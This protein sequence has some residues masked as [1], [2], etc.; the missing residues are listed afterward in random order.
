VELG[1]PEA[2]FEGAGSHH[3]H[4]RCDGCGAVAAVGTCAVEAVIPRV[5][6]STGFSL[7]GHDL[8]FHGLCPTC[9]VP[10]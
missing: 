6:R 7:S 2:R 3:E 10:G 1:T 9:Q 4:V 8:V 5:E